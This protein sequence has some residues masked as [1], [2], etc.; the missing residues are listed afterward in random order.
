MMNV[1]TKYAYKNIVTH[2]NFFFKLTDNISETS[3]GP[4][5]SVHI[6]YVYIGHFT[7]PPPHMFRFLT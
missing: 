1:N 5:I 2:V 7:S 4:S 6:G 3:W